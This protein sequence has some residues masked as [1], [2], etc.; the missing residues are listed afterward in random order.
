MNGFPSGSISNYSFDAHVCHFHEGQDGLTV[1]FPLFASKKG[2]MKLRL[3]TPLTFL[4]SI[5]PNI[6]SQIVSYKTQNRGKFGPWFY[7]SKYLIGPHEL[8]SIKQFQIPNISP[9]LHNYVVVNRLYFII[10][11][12]NF[13]TFGYLQQ[14]NSNVKSIQLEK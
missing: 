1:I 11:S 3:F 2:F 9:V 5:S 7:V 6:I 8:F 13:S 12:V 4:I 14:D 10:P